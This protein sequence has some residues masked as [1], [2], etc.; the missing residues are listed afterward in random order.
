MNLI[1]FWNVHTAHKKNEANR[2]EFTKI[3]W[4]GPS[5]KT[6]LVEDI[7][8]HHQYVVIQT[9]HSQYAIALQCLSMVQ[10]TVDWWWVKKVRFYFRFHVDFIKEEEDEDDEEVVFHLNPRFYEQQVVRNSNMDRGSGPEERDGGFP[11]IQGQ[12]FEVQVWL[13]LEVN[14]I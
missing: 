5:V 2:T 12:R 13:G 7:T 4:K 10:S 11:F 6:P 9:R 3:V 8:K 1:S 14:S